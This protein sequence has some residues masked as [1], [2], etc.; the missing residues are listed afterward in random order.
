MKPKVHSF[1]SSRPRSAVC[2]LRSAVSSSQSGAAL[3]ITLS[4]L[5]VITLLVIAFAVSMR[6][7][8]TAARNYTYGIQARQYAD[9]AV[10]EALFL[11]RTNTP[12]ITANAYWVSQPGRI[13]SRLGGN[14]SS[15]NNMDLL[16]SY[17]TPGSADTNNLNSDQSIIA[18]NAD[19]PNPSD[20]AITVNWVNVGTNGETAT[21]NNPIIGRYAFWV[22]DESTKID[23]NTANRRI[24]TSA[25]TNGASMSDVDLTVLAGVDTGRADNSWNYAQTNGYFTTE[26]WKTADNIGDGIYTTNKFYITAYGNAIGF[27]PWGGVRKDLNDTSTTASASG[28]T[29]ADVDNIGTTLTNAALANWFGTIGGVPNTFAR[30]YRQEYV[31]Q[32]LANIFDFRQPDGPGATICTGA[33]AGYLNAGGP[34]WWGVPMYYCGLRRY[35]FLNEI[36][37]RVAYC[38]PNTYELQCKLFVYCELVNPYNQDWTLGGQIRVY[39]DQLRFE[40]AVPGGGI[41]FP[42]DTGPAAGWDTTWQ[43]GANVNGYQNGPEEVANVPTVPAHSYVRVMIP[44]WAGRTES[45]VTAYVSQIGVRIA[46]VRFLQTANNDNTIRDWAIQP[47]FDQYGLCSTAAGN[48][49]NQFCFVNAGAAGANPINYLGGAPCSEPV[50]DNSQM[51][52][53]AKND[54]RV[55]TFTSW[56]TPAPVAARAWYRVG[57]DV[58]TN[59]TINAENTNI[60]TYASGSTINCG[61]VN[62]PQDPSEGGS[63]V[64][65]STFPDFPTR[66]Y[67]SV[68]ELGYIHTGLPWRT[69]SM[70]PS[71]INSSNFIPDWVV[72]DLFG[73][74]NTAV[75]GR[76]NINAAVTN[77]ASGTMPYRLKPIQALLTPSNL[78]GVATT[79]AT[80]IFTMNFTTPLSNRYYASSFFPN[81]YTFAGQICEVDT[82]TGSSGSGTKAYR[83]ARVRSLANLITTRG[84][85]FRVYGIGQ[86]LQVVPGLNITNILGEAKIQAVVQRTQ[87]A[88]PD[89]VWGTSDDTVNYK[90]IYFRYLQ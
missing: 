4:I 68:G 65:I 3:I 46:K 55:R 74:T 7:E 25:S 59:M 24:A 6:V 69:L 38:R 27:N 77:L 60:V 5:A 85:R 22:D 35:P 2:G 64:N 21:A 18:V 62:V 41:G 84:E 73:I 33:E 1:Q 29:R 89:N 52:G 23:V 43:S 30:K 20:R 63:L 34:G 8:K 11:I 76:I 26:Q 15:V 45:N 90:V 72:L 78:V 56:G 79:L 19:Y 75:A 58:G 87:S 49:T 12:A 47:D 88:G 48:P 40:V 80:N 10:D 54:P 86:A 13:L 9:M 44:V 82:L 16:F 32:I 37:L 66:D 28:F 50:L 36:G 67:Q 14:L 61:L 39:M 70:M 31:K 17:S 71:S 81:N 51:L 83:E 42:Y 57:Y 53:L